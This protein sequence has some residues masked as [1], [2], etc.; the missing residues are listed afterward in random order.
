MAGKLLEMRHISKTFGGVYALKD[1][2]FDLDQGEIHCL[3]GQNGSGK[4][5]L[6]KIITGVIDSDEGSEIFIQGKRHLKTDVKKSMDNGICVIYQDLSIFPS[7][8]VAEN[9]AFY[10]TIKNKRPFV[11]WR[12]I[13]ASA[14]KALDSI[15][16][17][18]DLDIP[19]ADLSIAGRQLV[20]IARALTLNAKLIIMDEPTSSLTRKEVNVLFSVIKDL[21]KKGIT[22]LFVSHK[23]DEII[24]IADRVTVIRDGVKIAVRENYKNDINENE[25][26]YLICGHQITYTNP[27]PPREGE[28]VLKVD[29]L[30][31][32]GQ[33]EDISFELKKGETLGIIGLL[34]S[35]RTELAMSLFGMNPS[36]HGAIEVNGQR[37]SMRNNRQAVQRGIAYVPEDR[38]L[39]GLAIGQNI[40]DNIT[41][42][43]LRTLRSKLGIINSREK[44]RIAEKWIGE[45][46]I[47]SAFYDVRA[48]V[49]SGGNQQKVV[50]S[51][52]LAANPRILILDQPTNGVDVVVKNAIYEIIRNLAEQ[53]LGIIIISDDARE[54]YH[55]CSR[56]LVMLRGRIQSELVPS[57]ISEMDFLRKVVAYAG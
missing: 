12:T 48:S 35:G 43:I 55:T 53:G 47:K 38:L 52:W 25:L 22:I 7:L 32:T 51:K 28:A 30:S 50:I 45:L 33:F 40:G 26:F 36:E 31:I 57:E 6:I 17:R 23:L 20:A 3:V 41:I 37:V 34:G 49:L 27:P 21:Q 54:I 39:Q 18:L 14:Q 13:R 16:E 24:E 29:K 56:I 8:T 15:K 11:D 42:T 9:I 19:V 4:S 1:V 46:G 2:D 5:T 10:D 44:I